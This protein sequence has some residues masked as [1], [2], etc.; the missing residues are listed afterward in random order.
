MALS[1]G[2]F[3]ILFLTNFSDYCYQVI[4]SIAQLVD[5]VSARLTLMHVYDPTCTTAAQAAEPLR[6]FFPEADRYRAC[7]RVVVAGPV[8]EAVTRHVA[9]RPV[10]LIVAPASDPIGIPRLCDRSLRAQLID[11]CG[12]PLWTMGR[13][14]QPG[15]L[16]QPVKHVACWLDFHADRHRHLAYASEYARCLGA[17]LHVLRGLPGVDEGLLMPPGHPD[18][19][20]HPQRAAEELAAMCERTSIEA[21]IHVAHGDGRRTMIQLLEQCDADLVFLRSEE[22]L[23]SR[24]LGLGVGLRLGDRTPCPSIHISDRP[25]VP[26]WRLEPVR[27]PRTHVAVRGDAAREAAAQEALAS[28]AVSID[29]RVPA[30]RAG[31]SIA[32]SNLAE[33]GLV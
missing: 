12:V 31:A 11:A 8:V 28:E 4:P 17:K 16:P 5:H 6:S 10:H 23:V 18:R 13:G 27:R 29:E 22:R 30:G 1:S 20:L 2:P 24:W 32:L 19:A 7:S 14:M 3:E 9:E 25:R 21:D 15:R 26:A 33:I